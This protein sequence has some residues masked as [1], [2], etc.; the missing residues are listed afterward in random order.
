MQSFLNLLRAGGAAGPPLEELVTL[1]G[2]VCRDLQDDPAQ[3]QP[4]VTAVL[5]SQLRLHLLG[6]AQVVLECARELAQ[7]EQHQAAR[8]LLEVG[9]AAGGAVT[10]QD[11][12][13]SLLLV[14]NPLVTQEGTTHFSNPHW[15]LVL[16]GALACQSARPSHAD[17][18][19]RSLSRRSA[20]ETTETKVSLFVLIWWDLDPQLILHQ[21]RTRIDVKLFMA[22]IYLLR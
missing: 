16:A 2:R 10:S 1:A 22:F 15:E 19:S 7:Q 4:F 6:N 20:V 8:R 11:G 5:D 18:G 21:N 17:P 3:V 9:L 12:L 14:R 13:L